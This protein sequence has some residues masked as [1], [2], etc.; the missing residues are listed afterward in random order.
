MAAVRQALRLALDPS[1]VQRRDLARHAGTAR[2]AYN[3]GLDRVKAT[4]DARRAGDATVHVPSAMTLHRE[5]NVW[6]RS[7]EGIPWWSEVSKCAPQEA[8][9]NLERGLGAYWG[10]SPRP[11]TRAAGPLPEQKEEGPV[12]RQLPAHRLHPSARPRGH[13]APDRHRPAVGGRHPLGRRR[14]R[15]TGADQRRHRPP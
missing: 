2:Y 7:P 3:W 5:W 1:P 12:S 9:R 8:F 10:Q 6:K 13:P 4:L 11:A 15:G 14:D